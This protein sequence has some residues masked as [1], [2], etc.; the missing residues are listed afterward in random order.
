[1]K[2]AAIF[3][4]GQ[5][6]RVLVEWMLDQI[7]DASRLYVEIRSLFGSK[8]GFGRLVLKARERT[9]PNAEYYVL[10]IDSGGESSVVSDL[11][12]QYRSLI[13]ANHSVI[14][15]LR[16]VAPN[17]EYVDKQKLQ[18]AIEN[19]IESTPIKPLIVLATIETEAWFIAEYS[20]FKTLDPRLDINSAN[21]VLGIDVTKDDI[22]QVPRPSIALDEIYATAGLNWDKSEANVKRTVNSL[23][24]GELAEAAGSRVVSLAPLL[25]ALSGFMS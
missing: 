20:H 1:M 11:N 19:V 21:G 13:A 14:I 4:E 10:I 3:V 6:E 17:C 7:I 23:N 9:N 22:E 5:T 12:E 15:A 24:F 16:D 8:K 18:A 25:A 2:K